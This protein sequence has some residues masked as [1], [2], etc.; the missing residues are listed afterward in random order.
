LILNP[1]K[2]FQWFMQIFLL[3]SIFFSSFSPFRNGLYNPIFSRPTLLGNFIGNSEYHETKQCIIQGYI[4]NINFGDSVPK[5]KDE[6]SNKIFGNIFIYLFSNLSNWK[7]KKAFTR[8]HQSQPQ[9]KLKRLKL[10]QDSDKS[11][12][13]NESSSE[14]DY[15]EI[16]LTKNALN[17]TLLFRTETHF[18]YEPKVIFFFVFFWNFFVQLQI[19]LFIYLL[20]RWRKNS[21]FVRFNFPQWKIFNL[22]C[23]TS[24]VIR[25]VW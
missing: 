20:G 3:L 15:D 12:S 8:I 2:I 18:L 1:L 19:Y 22:C 25:K 11:G 24:N 13:D 4:L 6:I 23:I 21:N 10:S 16:S 14:F 5:S 7:K 17:P 9:P